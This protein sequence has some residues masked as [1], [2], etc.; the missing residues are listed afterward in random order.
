MDS[1]TLSRDL[2]RRARAGDSRALSILFRRNGNA[3]LRW[4]R[5][6]LPRWA[7]GITDTTDIVQDVLLQTLRRIEV[8][9]DRGKGALQAYLRQA[10]DNR[11]ADV[12]RKVARHPVEE[13]G[14]VVAD[15]PSHQPSPYHVAAEH[16]QDE[17]YKKALA[18]LSVDERRLVV[19]R[20][21]L[22]YNYEQLA[23]ISNRPNAEAARMAVRRAVI[24]LAK[25]LPGG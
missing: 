2:L 3:L 22:G 24:K 5:G 9:E 15:L 1:A 19:G 10:V 25:R 13:L 20:M 7:R 21:E 12:L 16:E 23:V 4:A 18:T 14:D 6:R 17:R 8:F 11:I